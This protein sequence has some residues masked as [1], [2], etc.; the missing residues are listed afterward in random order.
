MKNTDEYQ[1]LALDIILKAYDHHK[2]HA[3]FQETQR[4][5]IVT[6]YL[7]LT[8]FIFIG[9]FSRY[10]SEQTRGLSS[11]FFEFWIAALIMH[12]LVGIILMISVSKLSGEFRRHFSKAEEI[13]ED[14]SRFFADDSKIA[15][16]LK[17]TMLEPA[18]KNKDRTKRV[19]IALLSNAAVHGYLFSLIT[20]ADVNLL[21]V[22]FYKCSMLSVASVIAA[23]IWFIISSLFL[24]KYVYFIARTNL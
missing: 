13:V 21:M 5:W 12:F 24:Y 23:L 9:I 14:L 18:E 4:S 15:L 16:L 6:A 2:V 19:A 3:R 8:G 10:P 7:T 20:A 22:A 11:E 17:K 1:K